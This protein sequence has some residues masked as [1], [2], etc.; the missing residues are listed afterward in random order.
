MRPPLRMRLAL[1][2]PALCWRRANRPAARIGA[3]GL[4]SSSV[5]GAMAAAAEEALV[6]APPAP[7]TFWQRN[8]RHLFKIRD[9][10][11]PR[12]EWRESSVYSAIAKYA[13]YRLGVVMDVDRPERK[14]MVEQL[15][16]LQ[17]QYSALLLA[18]GASQESYL[19]KCREYDNAKSN[20]LL[21][22]QPEMVSYACLCRCY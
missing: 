4:S 9:F 18:H 19:N 11:A 10:V 14:S 16:D 1:P 22:V 17:S 13:D 12:K 6:T 20:L 8:K 21:R 3:R 7:Q 15:V 5:T 2:T